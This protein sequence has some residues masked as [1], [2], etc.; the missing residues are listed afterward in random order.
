[1][2]GFIPLGYLYDPLSNSRLNTGWQLVLIGL[3]GFA[4]NFL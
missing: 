4:V 1:M 3:R 2:K